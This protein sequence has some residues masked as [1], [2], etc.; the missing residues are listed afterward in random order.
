MAPPSRPSLTLRAAKKL[1]ELGDTLLEV[2]D[3]V[4]STIVASKVNAVFTSLDE[5]LTTLS[6]VKDLCDIGKNTYPNYPSI[7]EVMVSAGE[8]IYKSKQ[9]VQSIKERFLIT[10]ISDLSTWKQVGLDLSDIASRLRAVRFVPERKKKE[11]TV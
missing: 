10:P 11:P 5:V 1:E 7:R 6:T 8:A 3:S 4:E 2:N 9:E